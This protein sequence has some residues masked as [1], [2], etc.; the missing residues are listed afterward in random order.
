MVVKENSVALFTPGL[1]IL[2]PPGNKTYVQLIRDKAPLF[3]GRETLQYK[4]SGYFVFR[5]SDLKDAVGVS[6][7]NDFYLHNVSG[8]TKLKNESYSAGVSILQIFPDHDTGEL[9]LGIIKNSAWVEDNVLRNYPHDEG[10]VSTFSQLNGP[11]SGFENGLAEYYLAVHGVPVLKIANG[12]EASGRVLLT[13]GDPSG[14]R[15]EVWG[16]WLQTVVSPGETK[17]APKDPAGCEQMG[18]VLADLSESYQTGLREFN[19]LNNSNMD[20]LRAQARAIKFDVVLDL[21]LVGLHGLSAAGKAAETFLA[22]AD[23]IGGRLEAAKTALGIVAETRTVVLEAQKGADGDPSGVWKALHSTSNLAGA[24][25]K[26]MAKLEGAHTKAFVKGMGKLE[27]LS[28]AYSALEAASDSAKA[29]KTFTK[30]WSQM[31]KQVAKIDS[32][33]EKLENF[34]ENKTEFIKDLDL[35]KEHLLG[36]KAAHSRDCVSANNSSHLSLADILGS[37]DDVVKDFRSVA[38]FNVRD[39]LGMAGPTAMDI[40]KDIVPMPVVES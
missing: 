19:K 36:L 20:D 34:L 16:D 17:P 37:E 5:L 18:E 13:V 1:D 33:V 23:P 27:A 30:N 12:K 2:L 15:G 26:H 39:S 24:T 31:Q 28:N 25:V 3:L 10:T 6:A 14:Q 35:Q 40:V 8:E 7:L 9:Q 38:N 22:L 21:G 11:I 29:F 4:D 32:Q